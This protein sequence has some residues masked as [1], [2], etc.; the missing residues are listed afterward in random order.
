M[1]AGL[2]NLLCVAVTAGVT[3]Q[4]PFASSLSP[5]KMARHGH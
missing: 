3:S 2:S 5:E 4:D 1:T